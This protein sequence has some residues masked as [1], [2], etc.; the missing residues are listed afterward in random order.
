MSELRKMHLRKRQLTGISYSKA[1]YS[2]CLDIYNRKVNRKGEF[3][4]IYFEPKDPK[5]ARDE[6]Q[7]LAESMGGRYFN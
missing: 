4:A 6:K 3:P 5:T 7:K 2:L 1:D